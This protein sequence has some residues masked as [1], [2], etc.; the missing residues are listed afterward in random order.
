MDRKLADAINNQINK[1]IYSSYLYLSMASYFDAT[2]LS[3]F[4][5]WM[6]MQAQ[7]EM[8]HA[9]KFY[10]YLNDCGERVVLQAIE[11]PDIDFMSVKDVFEKT[12]AHEQY[13]TTLINDLYSL[14]DELN[15]NAAK[16]ML[17]W[18]VTEQ[19]EEEKNANEI[20]DKLDL[21]KEDPAGVLYL[22]KELAARLVPVAPAA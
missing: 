5:H 19:V 4:S 8:I 13:V 16:F 10:N 20:L 11:Q 12:L 9:M 15:D 17:H 18:F 21:I 2:S 22:D 1:E 14:A 7:E 6:K 3:G